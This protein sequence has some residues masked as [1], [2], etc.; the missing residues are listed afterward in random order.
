[1]ADFVPKLRIPSIIAGTVVSDV[2][3]CKLKVQKDGQWQDGEDAHAF[4][5]EIPVE[6]AP[7]RVIELRALQKP[8]KGDTVEFMLSLETNL[9]ASYTV[10]KQIVF[11]SGKKSGAQAQ[12]N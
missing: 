10:R 8:V 12:A 3:P 4:N 2:F 6:G 5:V 9:K 1:M 11:K 7:P